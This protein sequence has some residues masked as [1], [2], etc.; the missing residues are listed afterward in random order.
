MTLRRTLIEAADRGVGRRA[1]A[2]LSTR[3]ARRGT[4]LDVEI[5]YDRAWVHRINSTYIPV[6][7]S[8]EYRRD[9]SSALETIF[10]PIKENWLFL[11]EPREG[12]TIV[13]I[14]A[15]D[16]LDSIVFSNAVGPGGRVL[17]VEAHPATF[18]LLEQT[19][20]LNGLSNVIPVQCAVMDE[21]GAVSMAEEGSHRDLYT[22]LGATNGAKRTADVPA[23]TL[24]ELCH[25]HAIERIDLLKMNIEGAERLALPGA[26]EALARTRYVCIACHDFISE[27]DES[28]ATKAFVV[29][30]LR[31]HGFEL[32]LREEHP[33][34]W[35]RD[36]VHGVRPAHRQPQA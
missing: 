18:V 36:H 35:V 31:D 14:G 10:E 4:E 7:D 20:T 27:G 17:A 12:D 34:P 26:E 28:L 23:K 16:G 19:C 24:D 33:Q 11:Y 5:L 13:D 8:F 30:F 3:Q 32:T 1:L 2:S 15:G 6:S 22:V 9:W 25:E 29:E 21:S